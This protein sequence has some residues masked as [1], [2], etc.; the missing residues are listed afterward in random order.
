MVH[1]K[2]PKIAA[3]VKSTTDN[4]ENGKPKEI[5][6]PTVA[7]VDTDTSFEDPLCSAK[8]AKKVTFQDVTTAAFLIKGGVECTPC[9]VRILEQI[10]YHRL[11]IKY[12]NSS[13]INS[14]RTIRNGYLPKERIFTTHWKVNEL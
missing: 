5:A 11:L 14:F 10:H 9:P 12:F 1:K 6:Q 7:G 4:M 8:T 2:R 3:E 13:A